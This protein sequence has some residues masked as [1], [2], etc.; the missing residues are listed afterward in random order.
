MISVAQDLGERLYFDGQL[1]HYECIMLETLTNAFQSLMDFG[2]I[3]KV[4]VQGAT[5]AV[6]RLTTQ[7]KDEMELR[8]FIARLN[9]YRRAP[10]GGVNFDIEDAISMLHK[11]NEL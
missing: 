3:E 6:I 9:D 5:D 11:D 4:K 10:F 1:Y 2:V 8:S 7:Y